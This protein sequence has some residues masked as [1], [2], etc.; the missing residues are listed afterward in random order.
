LTFVPY[1]RS[2]LSSKLLPV[3][4]REGNEKPAISSADAVSINTQRLDTAMLEALKFVTA[5][6]FYSSHKDNYP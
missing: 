1:C 6:V 5:P 4:A 2:D 3:C